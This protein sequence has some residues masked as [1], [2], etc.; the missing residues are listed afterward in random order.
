[1]YLAY[2]IIS[3]SCSL[4]LVFQKKWIK[5]MHFK[6]IN[7]KGNQSKTCILYEMIESVIFSVKCIQYGYGM[8]QYLEIYHLHLVMIK[9]QTD[10]YLKCSSICTLSEVCFYKQTVIFTYY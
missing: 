6:C 2:D 9:I 7:L 3:C 10:R 1:M 4:F 5:G 8:R